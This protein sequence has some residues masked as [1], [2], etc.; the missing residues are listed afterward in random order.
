MMVISDARAAAKQ[1]ADA[2]ERV[3]QQA[4]LVHNITN[5][6]VMNTTANALLAIG[7][8]PAM[9]HAIDEVEEFVAISRALV[10]N[11][12]TLSAPWVE[13]MRAAAATA[14]EKGVPWI[15]DPVGAGAT[16]FR[17]LVSQELG[18][19]R[20]TAIRGNA[21][22]IV[23]VSGGAAKTKGVDSTHGSRDSIE[24]ARDLA[25]TLGTVVAVTGATDYVTDGDRIV[26]ISNGH[27]MMARV[28]GLGCTA[29]A[30]CGAF[31]AVAD[32]RLSAV[33][34]AL[35]VLG[36]AGE[37]AAERAQGPGS[38]QMHILDL[39][40]TMDERLLADRA[41]IAWES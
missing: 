22:E 7:A 8:S 37:L 35:A 34:H 40:Y 23:A 25:R 10:I 20:P 12:G 18:Q 15:L 24:A 36:V 27:P 17:T 41:R 9:V 39:L 26:A 16:S 11:V 13:A 38:L 28:T 33:A 31:L 6:V 19:A 30:L 4:P 2:L 21:S 5:Y 1:A 29:T 14:A 32:D 3:R